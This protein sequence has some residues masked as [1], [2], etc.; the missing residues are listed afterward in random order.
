LQLVGG[1]FA[2]ATL[3]ASY[4]GYGMIEGSHQLV[5]HAR[6][7]DPAVPAVLGGRV[8]LTADKLNLAA[9]WNPAATPTQ[10]AVLV[11]HGRG[12]SKAVAWK[13][14]GFLHERF[15]LFLLDFRACGE[16]EGEQGT[17]G[18]FEI[19]DAQA[20]MAWLDQ[21][22]A[23]VGVLG[24]SLGG[25][26][27][28]D[29][30]ARNPHVKAVVSDCAFDTAEDAIRP[31]VNNMGYPFPGAMTQAILLGVK[32]R[33][34]AWLPDSDPIASVAKIAPRPLLLFHGTLD[35]ETPMEDASN[36]LRAA[37]EP[38]ELVET[39]AGHGESWKTAGYQ[40]RVT[41][42]FSRSL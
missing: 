40:E 6:N 12:A 15:N 24:E 2:V 14:F 31:R 13:K 28:I 38:K 42:F 27:A 19:R 9:W 7:Q 3:C 34:G 33:T 18:A 29:L 17:L 25:A 39:K 23:E 1:G 36:L 16:S 20:A 35:F 8:Q 11:L 21:R 10:R 30:A 37:G 4:L 41:T 32:F 22:G 26:V 5:Y